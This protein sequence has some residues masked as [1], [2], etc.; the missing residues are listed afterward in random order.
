[1]IQRKVSA[2]MIGSLC[3]MVTMSTRAQSAGAPMPGEN[4]VGAA[5]AV[6]SDAIHARYVVKGP[7]GRMYPTWHPQ[8]DPRTRCA[9][10]HEHGDNPRTSLADASLPAFGYIGA[11]AGMDEPHAG[12]KV[13]VVNRGD[14]S[15]EDVGKKR[16][17]AIANTRVVA[18]MGTSGVKRFGQRMHSLEYDLVKPQTGH[19][20][21]I[22]GMADTGLAG[23]ICQR[24][25]TLG[26]SNV[27]DN[28]G[29]VFFV[30]P[31]KT[32]CVG[33]GPYEIWSF[34]LVLTGH[35]EVNIATA[36]FDPATRMDPTD[37]SRL[38]LTGEKGCR[39][40]HYNGPAYWYN[41]G[42]PIVFYTDALGAPG[43]TLRQE[44]SRHDAVGIPLSSDGTALTKLERNHCA[45]G[46]QLPN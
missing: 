10:T 24:D 3:L 36:A 25:A 13:F 34:R 33:N 46:L 39:R 2:A 38:V 4:L 8:I 35:A 16:G 43:G 26:D 5:A 31:D 27:E 32:A 23:D 41:A 37:L 40:E 1:M 11:Q 29:R 14:R 9:F 28:I 30:E 15:P 42:K 18:H 20:M 45:E 12:F 21:H 17:G 19:F 6:C 44:V 7:D 22:Q